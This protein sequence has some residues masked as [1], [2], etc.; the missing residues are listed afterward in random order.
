MEKE[1]DFIIKK[2][3]VYGHQVDT[4]RTLAFLELVN[5]KM[6]TLV[7]KWYISKQ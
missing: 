5:Y 4:K 7:K 1:S 6:N 2:V 3:K